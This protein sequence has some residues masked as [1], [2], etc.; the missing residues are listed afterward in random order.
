MN[1]VKSYNH[2]DFYIT[3]SNGLTIIASRDDTE[4]LDD[5]ISHMTK[6]MD[7]LLHATCHAS[8]IYGNDHQLVN[9]LRDQWLNHHK[10][11]D[12]LRLAK[13]LLS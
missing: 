2:F 4:A 12:K 1:T 11:M 7:S 9:Q 10:M 5:T 8:D 3:L 6:L 13:D